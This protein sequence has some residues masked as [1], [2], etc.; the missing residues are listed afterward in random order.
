[1]CS[2]MTWY[3]DL[4]NDTDVTSHGYEEMKKNRCILAGILVRPQC[5]KRFGRA[6][7]IAVIGCLTFPKQKQ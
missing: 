7:S 6:T 2:T 4:E 3:I 5:E 1:M